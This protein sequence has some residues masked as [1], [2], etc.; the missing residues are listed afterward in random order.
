MSL[1]KKTLQSC[2]EASLWRIRVLHSECHNFPHIFI[3]S[4]FMDLWF[5]GNLKEL[6]LNLSNEVFYSLDVSE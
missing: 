5:E 2:T 4:A 6:W 3:H 1:V